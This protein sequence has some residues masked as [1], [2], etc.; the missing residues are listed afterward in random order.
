MRLFNNTL[1]IRY[2]NCPEDCFECVDALH[3]VGDKYFCP[4]S[5]AIEAAVRVKIYKE[6][7]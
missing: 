4:I 7:T 5:Q 2:N 6:E 1:K 3:I